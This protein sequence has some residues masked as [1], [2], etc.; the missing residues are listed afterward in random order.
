MEDDYLMDHP[1]EENMDAYPNNVTRYYMG[2]LN[3]E[4]LG[5]LAELPAEVLLLIGSFV[6]VDEIV[7]YK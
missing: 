7:F 5:Y 1:P 2:I 3:Y 6:V 4:G